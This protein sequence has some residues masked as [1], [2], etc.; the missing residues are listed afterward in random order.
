MV[1]HFIAGS[2]EDPKTHVEVVPLEPW[3]WSKPHILKQLEPKPKLPEPSVP[4]DIPDPD[5]EVTPTEYNTGFRP[6]QLIRLY[7]PEISRS[8]FL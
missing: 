5:Y 2:L 7:F 4:E 8:S 1:H 3:T 6:G